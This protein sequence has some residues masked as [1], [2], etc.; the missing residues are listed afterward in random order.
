IPCDMTESDAKRLDFL[1][2]RYNDTLPEHYHGRSISPSDVVELYDEEKRRY[3][4][5]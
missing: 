1:F 4:R 3:H 2:L 5:G